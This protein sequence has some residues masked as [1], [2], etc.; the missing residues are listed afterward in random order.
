[1]DKKKEMVKKSITELRFSCAKTRKQLLLSVLSLILAAITSLTAVF[2][3]YTTKPAKME[4]LNFTLNCGK[5]LRVNDGGNT[6]LSFK[7]LDS[8]IIPASSVDGKNLFFPTDGTGFSDETQKMYFRSANVGDKNYNYIQIDF[9]L[10]AQDNFTA[11]YIDSEKTFIKV[12]EKN[13][14]DATLSV[15]RAAPL[16]AALWSSAN[17]ESGNETIV[18]NPL[19]KNVTTAAV[20]AVDR[21]S[22]K[23]LSNGSQMANAFF[24]YDY[25][26]GRKSVATLMKGVETK[27]SYIVWLEGTDPKC[28]YNKISAKDISI[29]LAFTT[30]WDNTETIRFRDSTANHWIYE[31]IN[32]ENYTLEL[33]HVGDRNGQSEASDYSMYSYKNSRVEYEWSCTFPGDTQ[34]DI[35]FILRPPANSSGDTYEFEYKDSQ[36]TQSTLNRE[37]N[38]LYVAEGEA[39]ANPSNCHG[40]WVATGDSDGGGTYI[41]DIDGEDF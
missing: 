7:N 22:G 20:A 41:G 4:G 1:M 13:A 38:R 10:T 26:V 39:T 8:D 40:Q 17:I 3:W 35:S 31:K 36:H 37:H 9:T 24:Q 27:F 33:H 19:D 15:Q 25:K 2:C 21:S 23:Y 12:K 32:S 28:T 6:D 16:R 5:E 11:L 18:F 34:N 14:D 29:N 30:S